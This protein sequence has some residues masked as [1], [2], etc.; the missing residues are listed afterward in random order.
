MNF[1][2]YANRFKKL[3]GK[4]IDYLEVYPASEGFIAYQDNW[5]EDGLLLLLNE[6]IFYEFIKADEVFYKNPRR[7]SLKDVQIDVN[8]AIIINSNAGLWGYLIGDTIRFTSLT[9]HR[10]IVTG[11]I[12]HFISA[13]GEH[14][15]AEEIES[16][17]FELSKT[18]KIEI[19]EFTVAPEV[20]PIH[21]HLPHHE[22]YIEF[23]KTPKDLDSFT[24]KLDLMLQSKNCYYKDLIEGNILQ[25]L[26]IILIQ[27]DGF[28][29]YMRS[30]GK[31]GGQNKMVHLSN[32][33][34]IVNEMKG[35]FL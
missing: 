3:I 18:E 15:I 13:F 23:N 25:P 9:P 4:K 20:N 30:K 24:S 17:L 22:W 29:S 35:Y 10:I 19:T 21:N 31:L 12:N 7:I 32:D 33:R 11:R 34:I 6:G 14:V 16:S 8:Y 5:M 2:P 26:K 1:E 28:K 27:L